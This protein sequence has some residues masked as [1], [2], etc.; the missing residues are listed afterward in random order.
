MRT[1]K[2]SWAAV[3][4]GL[5]LTQAGCQR[6]NV[7]RTIELGVGETHHVL[8]DPPKFQQKVEVTVSSP[9]VPISAYLLYEE[10][11]DTALKK[12]DKGEKN[13]KEILDRK[14]KAEDIVLSATIEANKGFD[15]MLVGGPKPTKV[16]VKIVGR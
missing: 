13:I 2:L 8:I 1:V 16:R 3:V 5:L 9:G 12:L 6:L 11:K 14:E 10:D 7:N 4:A 15:V